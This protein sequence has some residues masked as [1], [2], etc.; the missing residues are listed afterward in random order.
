MELYLVSTVLLWIAVWFLS[1]S[2]KKLSR[3]VV[4]IA[5]SRLAEQEKMLEIVKEISLI[6]KEIK[7]DEE[8]PQGLKTLKGIKV[9]ERA[10][11]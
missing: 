10:Y 1:A 9:P 11:M 7:E 5:E 4:H 8:D 2:I 6:M 3:A